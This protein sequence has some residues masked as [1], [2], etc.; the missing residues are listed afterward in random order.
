MD[1]GAENGE[2]EIQK[3]VWGEAARRAKSNEQPVPPERRENSPPG[4]RYMHLCMSMYQVVLIFCVIK[5]NV[6]YERVHLKITIKK[7]HNVGM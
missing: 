2:Y 1:A 7:E 4:R 5:R 3:D 6:T